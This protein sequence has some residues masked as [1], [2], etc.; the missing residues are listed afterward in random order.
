MNKEYNKP[1]DTDGVIDI[2][3]NVKRRKYR[4]ENKKRMT[5]TAR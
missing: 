5:L 4:E 1:I 2:Y 3:P